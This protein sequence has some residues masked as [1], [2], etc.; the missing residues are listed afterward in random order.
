MIIKSRTHRFFDNDPPPGDPPPGDPPPADKKFTQED[1][2]RFLAEE[3]RKQAKQLEDLKK[4][5]GLTQAER[6]KLD[7]QIKDLSAQF[8]TKEE[9]LVEQ[10]K[11]QLSELT[12]RVEDLGKKES[13]WRTN[14]AEA[15]FESRTVA[16]ATRKEAFNPTIVA[17]LLKPNMELVEVVGAD[18]KPSGRFEPRVKMTKVDGEKTVNVLVTPEDA[19]EM[20]HKDAN[21]FGMLFKSTK[22]GGVGGSNNGTGS[23]SADDMAALAKSNPAAYREEYRKQHYATGAK[24]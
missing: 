4:V 21:Q 12:A 16:A 17:A 10:H 20:M 5:Q 11:T 1:V 15:T 8:Q 3:K 7:K 13:F 19:V 24:K 14:F 9:Q 2:N 23:A 6:D 22:P 18:G